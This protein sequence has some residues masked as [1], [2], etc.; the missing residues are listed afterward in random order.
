MRPVS[1]EA[2]GRLKIL[3]SYNK[4]LKISLLTLFTPSPPPFPPLGKVGTIRNR[5]E[6]KF[7]IFNG[8]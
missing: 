8:Y 5:G 1:F 4:Y 3:D 6:G 7:Q 2:S